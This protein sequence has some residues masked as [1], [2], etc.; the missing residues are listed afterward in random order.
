MRRLIL[1]S[2][3]LFITLPPGISGE[4]DL[5]KEEI[6]PI[7]E[8]WKET[9][10]YG[11]DSEIMQVI[12]AIKDTGEH[13]LD[14]EL[15]S[16]LKES[17]N[18]KVQRSILEYFSQ[19]EYKGAEDTALS[20]LSDEDIENTELIISL[21]HYLS[22]IDSAKSCRT[23]INFIENEDQSVV[24]A[25]INALGKTGDT[26]IGALLLDKLEDRDFSERLK[27][28]IILALGELNYGKATEALISIANNR[29]E[30]RIRRMYACTAL[31]KIGDS[32]AVPILRSLFSEKDSL[33]KMYAASA[34]SS[35]DMNEVQDL[36]IQGLKDSNVKVRIA[37]AKALAHRDAKKAVKILI[38]KAK[39]DPE[40]QLRIQAI[41]TL[42]EIGTKEACN[43]LRDLYQDRKVSLL[44]RE[45]ALTTLAENDLRASIKVIN[46]VMDEE[47]NNKD[48][49]VLEFTGKKLSQVQD[50]GLKSIFTTY[51]ESKNISLRI[52]GI[53]GIALNGFTDLRGKIKRVS[54]EDPHPAVRKVALSALEK[55]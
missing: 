32:K 55:F 8:D 42:G 12:E 48:Q 43:F 54:E 35:F 45:I 18:S 7:T 37:S 23:L 52:Y 14:K 41:K 10:L 17:V 24:R 51:L 6:R 39:N 2:I 49:K 22:S 9:L 3:V 29:D 25:A 1:L 30:E 15:L 28:D 50:N 34:L 33:I 38:Y 5:E 20:L 47:W 40:K 16:T 11:I 21:I 31:G 4:N 13:S 46:R 53:R 36:L 26:G 44:Y 19:A 27:A